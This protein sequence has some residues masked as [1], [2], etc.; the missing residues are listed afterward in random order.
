[1]CDFFG[2]TPEGEGASGILHKSMEECFLL[3]YYMGFDYASYRSLPIERR[4]W[5]IQ[6]VEKEINE[7]REKGEP[8]KAPSD[9]GTDLRSLMN[10]SRPDVPSKLRRFS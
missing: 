2:L 8:S 4:A 5:F 10:A 3:M 7:A 1:M 6:R 9:T